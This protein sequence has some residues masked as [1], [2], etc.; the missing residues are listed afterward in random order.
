MLVSDQRQTEYEMLLNGWKLIRIVKGLALLGLLILPVMA[1]GALGNENTS[2]TSTPLPAEET[3][4]PAATDPASPATAL[5]TELPPTETPIDQPTVVPSPTG[6]AFDPTP[7]L[8]PIV[9]RTPA[10][11]DYPPLTFV[12][13]IS[14][15]I[16]ENN[17]GMAT[18]T[19]M[20]TAA[21]GSGQ[22]TYYHD[23]ILQ[24]GPTFSYQ[25]ATCKP[26][27]GSVRVDSS[28]GQSVKEDYFVRSPCPATN[29]PTP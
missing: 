22:Y 20:I 27:P 23:D 2:P 26:R 6:I 8:A 29:T 21:G 3:N 17:P 18:A 14:W 24:E 9:S 25:W 28:D 5:P 7:T 19:I 15:E 16:D 4:P 13:E 11:G 12:W 1:C 10:V